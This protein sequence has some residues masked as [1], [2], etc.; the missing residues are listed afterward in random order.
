[1]NNTSND[2]VPIREGLLTSPLTPFDKVRIIGSKCNHCGEVM[3]GEVSC[4]ANCACE[5]TKIIPLSPNG[6]LWTYTVI[7]HRPPGSY[8]GPEPFEPFAEGL[9]ELPEGIRILSVLDCEIDKLA[10]GMALELVVHTLYV[11]D[12]GKN[13]IAFKFRQ[14]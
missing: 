7:R 12:Q 9:V 10:I 3:L 6:N 13:V 4:C 2:E 14:A 8:R 1:M 11:D 5:E